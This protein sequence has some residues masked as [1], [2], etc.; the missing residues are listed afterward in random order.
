MSVIKFLGDSF[1]NAVTALGAG[2]K[3]AQGTYVPI[4]DRNISETAYRSSTWYGKCVEIP[5]EDSLR[6]WRQWIAK[7]EQVEN[8]EG[9]ESRL[10]YVA[11]LE[12]AWIW[13]RLHGGA[14]I[15]IVGP[16]AA[17]TP[18]TSAM[19]RRGGLAA[20]HPLTVNELQAVGTEFDNNILSPTF[21]RPLMWR[22]NNTDVHPTRVVLLS[23]RRRPSLQRQSSQWGDP[24][25]TS[26]GAACM[27]ADSASATIA[28]LM[29]EAKV[30][31]IKVRGL[32]NQMATK[33]TT[34]LFV[35]RFGVAN[36]L[37]SVANALLL[38]DSDSFETKQINFANLHN[39]LF[40]ALQVL[41]GASDIPAV[42]LLGMSPGGL[43]ASGDADVRNYYDS[44]RANQA[45]RLTP[46]I[47]DLDEMLIMS[48]LG[49]R[50]K[51]VWYDWRP[52]WQPTEQQ[53]AETNRVNSEAD[54]N[55]LDAGLVDV[56]A[57]AVATTGRMI[58]SGLYPGLEAAILE[59]PI[60][61]EPPE[62]PDPIEVDPTAEQIVD[63]APTP[64]YVYRKVLNAADIIAWAESQGITDLDP[65][66]ELHVTVTYSRAAVS[67]LD[68]GEPFEG[69]MTIPAGGPRVIDRFGTDG[70]TV[71]LAFVS[72]RLRWR[73]SD[74]VERGA[75]YD[76]EQYVPHITIS[77]GGT[78]PEDAEPYAGEI[79]LGPEIFEALDDA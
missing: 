15:F 66:E 11:A 37:K 25:W 60:S 4:V 14:G 31:V 2:N 76:W 74:M 35:Q 38:D 10:G 13:Q 46:R 63:A 71:V 62:E 23:Q 41:S 33:E 28:A 51:E 73:H 58:N 40:A 64:L 72:S 16:G 34:D 68:M 8:L 65:A 12:Q 3:A 30:D 57:M 44:L 21:G 6:E 42:R 69:E 54:R 59:F 61:D 67:W 22:V 50:P 27:D 45:M 20:L 56:R 26:I 39:V 53:K 5:V 24:L 36:T 17:N 19:I 32:T 1:A 29:S 78:V 75:S 70:T 55:Y 43:N 7:P 9:E 77:H 18:L 49:T 79:V 48:A 52:L 47:R